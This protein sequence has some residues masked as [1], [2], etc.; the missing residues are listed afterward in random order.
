VLTAPGSQLSSF[1]QLL[2]Q[3]FRAGARDV[4]ALFAVR[5]DEGVRSGDRWSAA[6]P[7][8]TR[9]VVT[10]RDLAA[11]NPAGPARTAGRSAGTPDE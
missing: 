10:A 3:R 8:E 4:Q 1:H 6:D 7:G 11:G 5:E 2:Q 9:A